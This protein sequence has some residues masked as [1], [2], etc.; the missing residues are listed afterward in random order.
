LP[1]NFPLI[2]I[3]VPIYNEEEVLAA[4]HAQL[5]AGI[6]GLAE[7]FCITYID[8]GS[9]DG[10]L[11]I[12]RSLV[13]KDE[14]STSN[15][16]SIH[17]VEL[18]RNF[19]HQAAL[20]AGLDQAEGDYI[21]SMDGDGQ[22]PPALLAE[23][24]SLAKDGYD[25]VLTQRVGE[26]Q[27]PIFKRL[28]SNLFYQIT[29]RIANT[30]I[31]PDSSDFRL[32]SRRALD[33]LRSMPEYH[34]FLR[35]MVA[36]IGFRSVILPFQ[37]AQR[38]A[39]TSKYSLSKMVR[40]AMDAI[41]SFSLVPLYAGVSVGALFLLMALAEAIYVLQ[42]W[43]TGHTSTLAPGWSSLMFVLLVVG[44]SLM[45]T[46]GITGIYIGYIFQEVKHR[47]VYLVRQIYGQTETSKE[48]L[49]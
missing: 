36:W 16:I 13:V 24:L 5:M 12:L 29:N 1:K 43:I 14:S 42:F 39:G 7:D 17:V 32:L 25:I 10:T 46:L 15:S 35:G 23:M 41:F 22:H 19:G 47:P 11:A 6:Q 4:F 28:T 9:T 48:N 45:V 31:T 40:L 34:R 37:P 21:I 8:D 30:Q 3:V 26:K 2:D 38:L 44:G 20:C 33:A 49:P 27:L 18:S